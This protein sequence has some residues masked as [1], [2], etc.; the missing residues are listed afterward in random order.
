MYVCIYIYIYTYYNVYN[1]CFVQYE[2]G[3]SF[4]SS[5]YLAAKYTTT[6]VLFFYVI[7]KEYGT[8]QAGVLYFLKLK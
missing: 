6:L 3:L 2:S 1:I 8:N 7:E 5:I 4:Y